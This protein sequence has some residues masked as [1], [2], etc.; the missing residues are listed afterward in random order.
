MF[1]SFPHFV[2]HPVLTDKT[3]GSDPKGK[4]LLLDPKTALAWTA[5]S[6]QCFVSQG[7]SILIDKSSGE[8]EAAHPKYRIEVEGLGLGLLAHSSSHLPATTS[9]TF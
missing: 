8:T 3:F 1:V 5:C 9:L 7:F 4:K 2:N 6:P